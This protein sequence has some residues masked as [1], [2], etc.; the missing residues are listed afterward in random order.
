MKSVTI[1]T[2]RDDVLHGMVLEPTTAP[3]CHGADL[4]V[5]AILVVDPGG[6]VEPSTLRPAE[7]LTTTGCSPTLAMVAGSPCGSGGEIVLD[8]TT[9][10]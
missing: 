8:P 2:R 4:T 10:P 6:I 3:P 9:T 5:P 7:G 1:N